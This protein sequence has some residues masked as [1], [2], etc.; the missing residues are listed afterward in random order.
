MIFIYYVIWPLSQLS[1]ADSIAYFLQMSKLKTR[2]DQLSEQIQARL[3]SS[4]FTIT[5][6]ALGFYIRV[7]FLSIQ[8]VIA[9][10]FGII[11]LYSAFYLPQ[12]KFTKTIFIC[13]F[14]YS[15]HVYDIISM[16]CQALC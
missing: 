12:A 2:E 4:G 10:L 15:K 11:L 8:S 3:S 7:P 16:I 1:E 5:V 9:L 14:I 6:K 13:A